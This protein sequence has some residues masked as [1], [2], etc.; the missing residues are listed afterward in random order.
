MKIYTK[1]GDNGLTS[2][3]GGNRVL[4]SD[5]RI[6]AYG[7]VDELNSYI[8]LIASLPEAGNYRNFLNIIQNS[9]F[10]MGSELSCS[11]GS[12]KIKYPRL[13]EMEIHSLE[14]AID[15]MEKDLKPLKDFILPGGHPVVAQCHI[16]RCVCRR[17][18]RKT[19]ALA[20]EQPVRDV[21][22]IY[23]NRLSDYLFVLARSVSRILDSGEVLW[24]TGKQ[25]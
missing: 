25:S 1:T 18:E 12:D 2:L 14:K 19:V 8:G 3:L 24:R 7:T 13:E 17:A 20:Q 16:A 15:D 23:L 5:I 21:I 11:P 10:N 6:E 4:K 22:V 9:L